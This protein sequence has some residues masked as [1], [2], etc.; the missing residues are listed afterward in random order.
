MICVC[1]R[2][3][4]WLVCNSRWERRQHFQMPCGGR[5]EASGD[6]CGGTRLKMSGNVGRAESCTLRPISIPKLQH[7]P[8]FVWFRKERKSLFLLLFPHPSLHTCLCSPRAVCVCACV[9]PSLRSG[10]G[11]SEWMVKQPHQASDRGWAEREGTTIME[12]GREAR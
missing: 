11:G 9:C 1:D 5:T 10:V 3:T 6:F 4:D 2:E 8:L 7:R 12:K